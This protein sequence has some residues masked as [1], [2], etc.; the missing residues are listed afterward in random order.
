MDFSTLF[1]R[2][3]QLEA[4]SIG[5]IEAQSA[6]ITTLLATVPSEQARIAMG[7][8]TAAS[9]Q[10]RHRLPEAALPHFQRQVDDAWPCCR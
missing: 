4:F 9:D 8:L 1:T 7:L 6:C 3:E 2:L 5:M 10:H